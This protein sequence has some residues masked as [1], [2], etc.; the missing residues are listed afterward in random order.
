MSPVIK[1]SPAQVPPPP[2]TAA[3]EDDSSKRSNTDCIYFLAS[4]LTCK[5]GSDCEY[6][7]CE[8][9]RTNPRDCFYWLNGNCLN[10]KC[11]F[12]HPPLDDLAPPQG[13]NLAGPS[14]PVP[15]S[16]TPVPSKQGVPCV[17]FQQGFCLK[18]NKCPF[19]HSPFPS[20][21]HKTWSNP[22]TAAAATEA[23]A[24][25]KSF[26]GPQ[27]Y[28][29]TIMGFN[30]A[31]KV[32]EAPRQ[33][34]A[35]SLPKVATVQMVAGGPAVKRSQPPGVIKEIP[36]TRERVPSPT[37]RGSLRSRPARFEN[38]IHQSRRDVKDSL[39]ETSP[40]F[41][42]LVDDELEKGEYYHDEEKYV[43]MRDREGRRIDENNIGRHDHY[44]SIAG[45]DLDNYHSKHGYDSYDILQDDYARARRGASSERPTAYARR[46]PYKSEDSDYIQNASD[47]RHRLSK[48]RRGDG[49]RSVVSPDYKPNYHREDRGYKGSQR[50]ARSPTRD[51]SIGSRLQGRIKLPRRSPPVTTGGH[52]RGRNL[53]R[54]SPSRPHVSSSLQGRLRDSLGVRLH[55]ESNEGR[56]FRG[57][58]RKDSTAEANGTE[59]TGPKRLLELK[60]N[61]RTDHKHQKLTDQH[62]VSGGKLRDTVLASSL[63]TERDTSFDAPE[64]LSE[65]LKRKRKAGM[66]A[67]TSVV[68]FDSKEIKQN[69][70]N[71]NLMTSVTDAA[72]EKGKQV[73]PPAE[74]TQGDVQEN[75]K[76]VI[77]EGDEDG[78]ISNKN[79]KLIE[80]EPPLPNDEEK[81][82]EAEEHL[83]D[84]DGE[85]PEVGEDYDQGD[86]EYDYEQEDDVEGYDLNEG[87][88][89]V[90]DVADDED[91]MDEDDGDDFAKKLGV[92]F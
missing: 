13:G 51:R 7:H 82:P 40:G 44:N 37:D 92:S 21:N 73:A 4:P 24:F 52:E 26:G 20:A 66:T 72:A 3:A 83:I 11:A 42:V 8:S 29:Q 67:S 6:R 55:D 88:V 18:G 79:V 77:A 60:G 64:P 23:P 68:D 47:L 35:N 34:Q 14:P 78:E 46:S 43:A 38:Q 69:D 22:A 89:D 33:P 86:G 16:G 12:R 90:G 70:N 85:E 59:F 65:I 76:S 15:P 49:L 45:G 54:S 39:R 31:P 32:V 58:M 48:Q 56:T 87:E 61:N 27:K 75:N 81:H 53:G 25:K 91:F 36:K 5:K 17:F 50:D 63:G 41:D 62:S 84:G 1:E 80:D 57:Q 28:T 9:A 74:Q 71:V 10:P 2:S 19:L 30:S